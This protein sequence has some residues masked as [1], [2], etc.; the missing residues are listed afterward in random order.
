LHKAKAKN[1]HR[2]VEVKAARRFDELARLISV[3]QVKDNPWTLIYWSLLFSNEATVN[4]VVASAK[5]LSAKLKTE[6]I[7]SVANDTSDIIGCE[8]FKNGRSAG[9]QEFE[10]H[11]DVSKFFEDRGIYLPA[12]YP[13]SGGKGKARK[14]WLAV[15]KASADTVQRADLIGL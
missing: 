7:T 9:V 11:E 14:A 10:E 8:Q 5:G 13:K 15:D 6:S 3:V 1:C 12:C 2:R 4:A